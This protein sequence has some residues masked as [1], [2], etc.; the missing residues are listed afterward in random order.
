MKNEKGY[1]FPL[2]IV[3]SLFIFFIIMANVSIYV[4]DIQFYKDT[5]EFFALENLMMLAVQHSSNHLVNRKKE[6]LSLPTGNISYIVN[7]MDD[8]LIKVSITCETVNNTTYSAS[9][10]YDANNEQIMKWVESE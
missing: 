9:Y 3:L 5:Q 10:V 6:T 1:I 7:E 2:T 8:G 4:R